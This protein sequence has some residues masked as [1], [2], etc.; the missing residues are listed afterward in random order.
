MVQR[1]FLPCFFGNKV[2]MA[3]KLIFVFAI[4]AIFAVD[5]M[6]IKNCRKWAFL[7]IFFNVYIYLK[8]MKF[9]LNGLLCDRIDETL[10]KFFFF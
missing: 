4:I 6:N 9:M 7:P 8:F 10:F 1:S 2:T 3:F 5:A